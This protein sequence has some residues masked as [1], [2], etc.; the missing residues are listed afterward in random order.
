MSAPLAYL[1]TWTTYGTWLPGD[2]RGWV[3]AG[4]PGIQTPNDARR[5]MVRSELRYEPVQ[6]DA[7]QRTVV[8]ETIRKH[9]DLRQWTIH[10]LNV[11]SNHIHLVAAADAAPEKV[12]SQLKSWCS[13]RLNEAAYA[14]GS[15]SRRK[16]WTE[17]GSTKWIN[18]AIYL[19]NAVRYVLERQ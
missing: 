19:E 6:L 9:C 2:G 11:R 18:D 7:S 14:D 5:S 3:E 4:K 17:H 12:M 13:R 8:S 16:W 10:A 15:C 1:I